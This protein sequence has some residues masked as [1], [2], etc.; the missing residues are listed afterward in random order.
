MEALSTAMRVSNYKQSTIKAYTKALK[1]NNVDVENI[2]IE[3][4]QDLISNSDKHGGYYRALLWNVI[5]RSKE[6]T[7][8][9]PGSLLATMYKLHSAQISSK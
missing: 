8:F 9:F 2:S 3:S 1:E 7:K 4:L 5:C 6:V